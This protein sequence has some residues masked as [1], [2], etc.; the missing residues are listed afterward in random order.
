MNINLQKMRK[1]IL[2]AFLFCQIALNSNAQLTNYA[3]I[4]FHEGFETGVLDSNWYKTSS[5]PAGR[6]RI[7]PTDSLIWGG[8]TAMSVAGNKFLGMDMPTGGTFNLNQAWLG[9]NTTGASNLV[10]S[11]WWSDWNDETSVE[12]G[13]YISQDAGVT[14]VK[15]FD[16]L[17]G[18]NPDLNWVFY[19]FNLDSINLVHGLNYGP[20]YVIKFQQYDD[21]YFAGGNDGFMFDEINIEAVVTSNQEINKK[22][23]SIFPN[24]S[25][26]QIN[27]SNSNKNDDVTIH[28]FN[29]MGQMVQSQTFMNQS[30]IRMNLEVESG[31]YFMEIL[32]NNH[33]EVAQIIKK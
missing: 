2:L 24:P 8:D 3:T 20:N 11:F 32:S 26:G 33:R 27:I 19:T 1:V 25:N 22:S 31:Y 23:F 29:A 7:W 10:F 9:L 4:P 13:I 21:Y 28:I 16:L 18:A 15:V 14:F 30:L 6:I 17:G 5:M 12:D